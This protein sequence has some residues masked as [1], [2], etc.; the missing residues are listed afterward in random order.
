M[1]T[2]Y[3]RSSRFA[4]IADFVRCDDP[5]HAAVLEGAGYERISRADAGRRIRWINA[6]NDAWS[7]GRAIG[8]ISFAAL[9]DPAHPEYREYGSAV[10]VATIQEMQA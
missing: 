10:A 3:V 7:D 6:E 9:T 8:P 1:K 4:N 5:A 2:Y